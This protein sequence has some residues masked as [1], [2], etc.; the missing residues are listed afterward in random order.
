MKRNNTITTNKDA[1]MS[2][3]AC[4]EEEGPLTCLYFAFTFEEIWRVYAYF[5][6]C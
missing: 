2:E 1:Y 5:K 4:E 6:K 3:R